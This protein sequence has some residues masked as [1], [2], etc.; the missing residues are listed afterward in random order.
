MSPEQVLGKDVDART[1]L[2]SLG[3]VLYEMV[4]GTLPFTGDASG[5]IF[6]AIL[7]KAPT[8][9]VRLNPEVPDELERAINKCLE[10]DRDLRYQHASELRA[11]LKRLKRDSDIRGVGGSPLCSARATAAKS[12]WPWLAAGALVVAGVLGWWLTSGRAPETT[13]EPEAPPIKITPFTTDGGYKANPRLSPD[14][15]KVAYEWRGD[16]TY[17]KALGPGTRPIRLTEHEAYE[18]SPVWSPDGRQIAFVRES[19]GGA[20]L[21]TVPALGGQERKLID[22][23][24]LVVDVALPSHP[25]LVPGRR[26]GS[27]SPRG[28]PRTSLLASFGS[29]SRPWRSSRSPRPRKRRMET[30]IRRFRRTDPAGVRP[31]WAGGVEA[32]WT[33][34]SSQWR[35]A[36]PAG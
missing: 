11:D 8:S 21:Y 29:R 32:I 18:A 15:E 33:C 17:V 34:G 1:D 12:A 6:D 16:M 2:F 10:K 7:H 24:G 35:G 14:G 27:P 13:P 4:T 5:A 3:V 31:S 22:L 26:A 25:V 28:P 23:S 9:P 20:T 36:R 30:S 19:E